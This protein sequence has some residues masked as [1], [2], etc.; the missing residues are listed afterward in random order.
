MYT[1]L[2]A[3][4]NGWTE[5]IFHRRKIFCNDFFRGAFW[6]ILRAK[7]KR[8]NKL[9]RRRKTDVFYFLNIS[10]FCP[11]VNIHGSMANGKIDIHF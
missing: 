10:Q 5:E 11:F 3:G 2:T 6:R 8:R 4:I 9:P 1:C 7:M